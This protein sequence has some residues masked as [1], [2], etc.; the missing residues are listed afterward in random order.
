MPTNE[1]HLAPDLITTRAAVAAVYGGATQGGIIGS[2]Q[3]PNVF[4]YSDP[5]EGEQYGY[6][7]DGWTED[8]DGTPIY[9]YTGEG[10]AGDQQLTRGNKSI[11]EHVDHGR[12]LHLFL[13][14]GYVPGS[15]T[16][17]QRYIGEV[18][19]DS[20]EPY[21]ERWNHDGDGT[22]RC[23]YVFRLRPTGR[24][25]IDVRDEDRIPPAVETAAIR[26]PAAETSSALLAP[27]QY[28]TP[29]TTYTP[30]AGPRTVTRRESKL[31]TLF[32]THLVG[33]GH[34]VGRYQLTIK[35]CRGALLTDLYDSTENVLYEVKGRSRRIDVR[36]AVA[37]LLDY[38]RHIGAPGLRT[39][40]LI[41]TEPEA[42]VRDYV[43]SLGIALVVKNGDHFNGYPL[44]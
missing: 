1:L 35:G 17:Y 3:T 28:G 39:A 27:E 20:V 14:N 26:V 7:F 21:L 11:L 42:D 4:I 34:E 31:S 22:L 16:K 23:V 6:T 18:V 8:D 43:E 19:V 9:H 24:S 30:S 44:A 40:I 32:E 5:D 12:A 38:R 37:Q 10:S 15:R 13:A 41:P 2:R 36:M 29:E 33:L 25:A